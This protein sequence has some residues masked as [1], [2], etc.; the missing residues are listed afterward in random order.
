MSPTVAVLGA[1][2][3][4][5]GAV[6]RLESELDGDA[7]LVWI[8]D[9]D[10]HLVLHES[11]RCIRDPSV[12]D[13]ITFPVEEIK[14]P[15]TTFVH[16]EVTGLDAEAQTIEL[17]DADDVDYDS[18]LVAIGSATAFYGIPGL[19]EHSHALKSPAAALSI[20]E[21]RVAAAKEA[22]R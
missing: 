16:S 12:R 10:Y 6:Q 8:S 9:T 2:Y 1:G 11:H 7:D 13:S 21:A 18:V 17:A 20:H 15:S 22:T 3:A 4:G 14:A 5:A 19:A